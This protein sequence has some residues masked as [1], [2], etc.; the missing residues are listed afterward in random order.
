MMHEINAKNI[1]YVDALL[2]NNISDLSKF[3][4]EKLLT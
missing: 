2:K 4:V 1:Y 3:F